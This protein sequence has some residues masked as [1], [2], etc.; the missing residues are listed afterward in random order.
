MKIKRKTRIQNIIPVAS[1]SDI[2]FLLLIFFMLSSMANLKKGPTIENPKAKQISALPD[3]IKK[4]EIMVDKQ[5][6]IFFEGMYRTPEEITNFFTTRI[7]Q[8]PNL[9]IELNADEAT[10]YEKIDSVIKALQQ[11][12]CYRILFVCKKIKKE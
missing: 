6:L 4:F 2:A 5:G 1:M 11:A 3:T 9:Y 12:E 8:Y 7:I 10:E